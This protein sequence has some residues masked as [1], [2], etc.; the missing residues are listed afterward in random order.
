MPIPEKLINHSSQIQVDSIC[1]VNTLGII[2]K[3]ILFAA[4]AD[5][6]LEETG[7]PRILKPLMMIHYSL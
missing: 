3:V 2:L 7:S 4:Y 6:H 5:L 1:S